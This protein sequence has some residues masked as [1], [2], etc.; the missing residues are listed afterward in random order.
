MINVDNLCKDYGSVQAVKGISFDV[1]KG[2]FFALLG[3]NGAGKSTTVEIL[4]TLKRPTSGS[5]TVDGLAIG[6]DDAAIREKIGIVFQY[7]VLDGLLSVRENLELRGA[8]Y[9]MQKAALKQRIDEL[10]TLLDLTDIIDRRLEK[11][12]G[13]QRRKVDIARAL[14][15]EPEILILD[16]P[17]TGLDPS[18]RERIWSLIDTLRQK[19][20]MTIILTTH[21]M[22][23]V[24]ACDDVVIIDKGT[25][26]AR[27]SA[28]NLRRAHAGDTLILSP[29]DDSLKTAL[30]NDKVDFI[31]HDKTVRIPIKTPF[32]GIPI[33]EAYR[34]KLDNFEIVKG[35][36]DDV[37]LNI[38]G[39]RLNP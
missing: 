23:E 8:L 20:A 26:I 7:S 11:L 3:P 12:S 10:I 18:M 4:S 13:G 34:D 30:E 19:N 21:Y 37:F 38:T 22:E 16:E 24:A 29:K 9:G 35:N 36:M 5:I 2:A 28:T 14:I 31:I 39:R 6:K 15:N 33:V 1:R 32:E 27:D 17:T 25:I